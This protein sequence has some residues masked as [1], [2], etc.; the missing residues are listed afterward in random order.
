MNEIPRDEISRDEISR[1]EVLETLRIQKAIFGGHKEAWLLTMGRKEYADK[2]YDVDETTIN[3]HFEGQPSH[4]RDMQI[5]RVMSAGVNVY[6][7]RPQKNVLKLY[8]VHHWQK[9]DAIG[10]SQGYVYDVEAIEVPAI[11][12]GRDSN[13]FRGKDDIY[14]V[15]DPSCNDPTGIAKLRSMECVDHHYRQYHK[16]IEALE[17]SLKQ[18]ARKIRVMDAIV[19]ERKS[20]V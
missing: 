18:C 3:G 11:S 8:K 20:M 9:T 6:L 7:A 17:A 10:K 14:T 2:V 5:E 4:C 15:L 13:E 1:D 16:R 12:L 19:S